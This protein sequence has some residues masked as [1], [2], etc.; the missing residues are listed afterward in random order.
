M[1]RILRRPMFRGGRVDSRGTGI[2]SGLMDDTGYADG[3]RV[4]FQVGGGRFSYDPYNVNNIF[5][6]TSLGYSP[7]L[8]FSTSPKPL[9]SDYDPLAGTSTNTMMQDRDRRIKEAEERNRQSISGRTRVGLP[10]VKDYSIYRQE[11]IDTFG[12]TPTARDLMDYGKRKDKYQ[13]STEEVNKFLELEAK[14]PVKT[15]ETETGTGKGTGKGNIDLLSDEEDITRQ[16]KLY[17]KL[18]GG[19]EAKSQAAYDA[20]LAAAPA[21]FKGKN[22]REA[23]PQVLESINKSGAFD[24]P[25][26][27]KQAAAQLAIQ[28]RILMDKAA[29]E[30]NQRLALARIAAESREKGFT[31]EL[32]Q[33][34]EIT[35]RGAIDDEISF[36]FSNLRSNEFYQQIQKYKDGNQIS[37]VNPKTGQRLYLK[38][39]STDPK[40]PNAPKGFERIGGNI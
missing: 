15:K 1:S 2:T 8:N 19:E 28:R 14:K 40:N 32:K 30:E 31:E 22:L 6:G 12:T 35:G 10:P 23:A 38:I 5:S 24:K 26:D 4:G 27:I 20:L 34:K 25:R 11:Y 36:D 7:T 9:F 21:F 13:E 29:A 16:A 39:K 17:E 18:L 37:V 33:I 3:G